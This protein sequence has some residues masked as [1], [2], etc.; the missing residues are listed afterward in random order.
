MTTA[1]VDG[2]A[3]LRR[4]Q[5]VGSAPRR[6]RL[7][8][9]SDRLRWWRGRLTLGLTLAGAMAGALIGVVQAVL[10]G[11]WVPVQALE[12]YGAGAGAG[13]GAGLALGLLLGVVLGLADRY[14][15]PQVVA[16]QPLWVQHRRG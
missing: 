13:A 11:S 14:V 9:G 12:S 10:A 15:L 1:A 5:A 2:A 3:D 7:V 6:L 8:G 16:G 4:V